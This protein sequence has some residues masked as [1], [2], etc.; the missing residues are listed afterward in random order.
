MSRS[1]SILDKM[2]EFVVYLESTTS[3]DFVKESK[4]MFFRNLLAERLTLED[5][6][7]VAFAEIIFRSR[8]KNAT[9]NI[10]FYKHQ[11]PATI[12]H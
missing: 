7:R 5:D 10:S 2:D 12:A 11:K 3:M 4:M 6:W 8:N 1:W 9:T